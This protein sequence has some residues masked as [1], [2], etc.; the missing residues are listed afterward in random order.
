MIN[1]KDCRFWEKGR[2]TPL[3]QCSCPKMMYGY[4]TNDRECMPDG[5]MLEND[6]GWGMYTGP[7]FGCIHA[8]S[9]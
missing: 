5:V 1:C 6:E 2:Q 9:K 7:M 8:E 3:G 4:G